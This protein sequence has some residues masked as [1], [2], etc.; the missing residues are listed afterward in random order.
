MKRMFAPE[1]VGD[2]V[3]LIV[4]TDRADLLAAFFRDDLG[5]AEC[6]PVRP[7]GV[8]AGRTF[9]AGATTI[10]VVFDAERRSPQMVVRL[11][12][13][14]VSSCA[15]RVRSSG[16][17]TVGPMRMPWGTTLCGVEAPGGFLV[18]F[19]EARG[20]PTDCGAQSAP[21]R[22]DLAVITCIDADLDPLGLLGLGCAEAHLLSNAGGVVTRD[23]VE[24]LACARR[25]L[26]VARVIV[27]HHWPCAFL[28]PGPL[29]SAVIL[30]PVE[31]LRASL[32]HLVAA[33][34]SFP[35]GAVV[36]V[37]SDRRGRLTRV[38]AA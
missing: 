17:A 31:R 27:L 34:L 10:E 33:P 19:E 5:L 14:D 22:A 30:S 6:P 18:E 36:G 28:A 20:V 8:G 4:H 29:P 32:A 13:D 11:P 7:G 21:G 15:D 25:R 12:V 23:L 26:G 38:E 2:G 9:R 35:P 3:R 1:S 24:D 16:A 37:L